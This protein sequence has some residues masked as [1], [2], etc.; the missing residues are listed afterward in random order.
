MGSYTKCTGL[1]NISSVSSTQPGIQRYT[2]YHMPV[3]RILRTL[4]HLGSRKGSK[5]SWPNLPLKLITIVS[6]L[7]VV[8]Q[9]SGDLVK[10]NYALWPYLDFEK[11]QK[12]N[13]APTEEDFMVGVW[14]TNLHTCAYGS[15][16]SSYFNC[17]PPTLEEY[18][19]TF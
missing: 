8:S 17:Y 11:L 4:L 1:A 13:L 10:C 12:S 16:T 2:V 14:L 15:T 9:S 7:R 5:G 18:L 6:S 3:V 19:D